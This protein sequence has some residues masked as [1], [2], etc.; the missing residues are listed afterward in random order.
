MDGGNLGD[1]LVDFTSGVSEVIS[2]EDD[3]KTDDLDK[4]KEL[5][6]LMADEIEDHALMCSAVKVN[7][8]LILPHSFCLKKS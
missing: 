2:I 5:F 4:K 6:K 3:Y 8:C 1:A 7:G